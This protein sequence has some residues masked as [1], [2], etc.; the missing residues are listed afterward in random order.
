MY[1]PALQTGKLRPTHL[2]VS[3]KVTERIHDGTVRNGVEAAR[4]VRGDTGRTLSGL[5]HGGRSKMSGKGH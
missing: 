3:L 2:T 5:E 4:D 1:H